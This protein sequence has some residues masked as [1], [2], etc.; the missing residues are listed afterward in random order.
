MFRIKICGITRPADAELAAAAGADAIGL[1]FFP[2]SPRFVARAAAQEIVA[3][4]GKSVRKIGL[5]VNATP[6]EVVSTYEALALDL[7]QLHG[8][9]PP[10]FLQ[11]LGGLPVLRAFRVGP[12]GLAPVSAYLEACRV[13]GAPPQLV[14]LDGY[15]PGL[16]G[17]TGDTAPWETVAKYRELRFPYPLILAGGLTPENVGRAIAQ[18]RPLGVD[19]A[20]GVE[21]APGIKDAALVQ[22][23]V[24][25]AKDA[26]AGQVPA[27]SR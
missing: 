20:S 6:A 17:G 21:S 15:Q 14:L 13:Y 5:V 4:A 7:V 9:E 27:E 16:Y 8:D 23:F 24:S 18:V 26:L 10:D 3:A 19:V 2:Q 12:S 1:N 11:Q 22:A 25:R